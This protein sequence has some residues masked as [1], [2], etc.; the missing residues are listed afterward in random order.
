MDFW[1]TS[2]LAR[3]SFMKSRASRVGR[4]RGTT[5]MAEKTAAH[6]AAALAT[7]SGM[8][9]GPSRVPHT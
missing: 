7:D 8:S 6:A 9:R 5:S 3:V 4:V 1:Q 2:H